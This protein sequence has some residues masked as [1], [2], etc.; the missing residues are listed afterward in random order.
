MESNKVQLYFYILS[1][2]T[3]V[4]HNY[5]KLLCSTHNPNYEFLMVK[6]V[7]KQLIMFQK[8]IDL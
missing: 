5:F 8:K 1:I 4:E 3:L 6:I 7:I 2:I